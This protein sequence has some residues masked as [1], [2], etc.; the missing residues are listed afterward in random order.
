M[1]AA[2]WVDIPGYVG[3]YQVSNVGQVKSLDR[4]VDF[5]NRHN[6]TFVPRLRKGT[7]LKP[8][9]APNGYLIVTLQKEGVKK[10]KTVHRLVA[11]TFIDNVYNL[12]QINHIDCIKVNNHYKNLEWCTP[13]QNL[14][15]AHR[16]NLIPRHNQFTKKKN[17]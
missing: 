14:L 1:S 15:H 16:H 2:K 10:W 7:L 6:K 17:G 3:Y 5:Y 8:S 4:V 12:P 13:S 9:T 11:E